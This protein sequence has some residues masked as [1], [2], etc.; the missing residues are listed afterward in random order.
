MAFLLFL[1]E[2][3]RNNALILVLNFGLHRSVYLLGFA[4]T[5]FSRG[6][7]SFL[8]GS[9]GSGLLATAATILFGGGLLFSLVLGISLLLYIY[10]YPNVSVVQRQLLEIAL[11]KRHL[12]ILTFFLGALSRSCLLC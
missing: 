4:P 8:L 1:V 5:L 3:G 12:V 10:L 9:G 2:L 11:E 7:S 6:R